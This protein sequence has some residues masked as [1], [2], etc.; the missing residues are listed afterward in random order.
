MPFITRSVDG[1]SE[2]QVRAILAGLFSL[3]I[4]GG[5]F[6]KLITADSFMG[7][8]TMAITYYFAKRGTEENSTK[9]P[10]A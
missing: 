9:P 10:V 1:N 3:A 5:F 6:C 7:I 4:I 2:V 8:A